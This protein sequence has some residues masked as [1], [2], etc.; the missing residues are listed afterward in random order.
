MVCFIS[1]NQCGKKQTALSEPG[2]S[3]VAEFQ[4]VDPSALCCKISY[5]S[6]FAGQ[7]RLRDALPGSMGIE[8]LQPVQFMP[9]S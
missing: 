3:Y 6:G 1:G 5:A 4:Q 9:A 2:V 7:R 8:P